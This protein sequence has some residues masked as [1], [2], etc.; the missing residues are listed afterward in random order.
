[1]LRIRKMSANSVSL[2]H[3]S[4]NTAFDAD[5]KAFAR[6]KILVYSLF[7]EINILQIRHDRTGLFVCNTKTI[8]CFSSTDCQYDF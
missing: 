2:R 6:A 4:K 5:H 1:M 7:T 3:F 8:D